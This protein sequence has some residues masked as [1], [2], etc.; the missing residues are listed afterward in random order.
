MGK[1][2][3]STVFLAVIV[4][5]NTVTVIAPT[6]AAQN[7]SVAPT[8]NRDS[9]PPPTMPEAQTKLLLSRYSVILFGSSYASLIYFDS[10]LADFMTINPEDYKSQPKAPPPCME[11]K[12]P[13]H[14][15]VYSVEPKESLL[16]GVLKDFYEYV[17]YMINHLRKYIFARAEILDMIKK[18][19]DDDKVKAVIEKS[20]TSNKRARNEDPEKSSLTN[21]VVLLA[22]YFKGF[23]ER[24]PKEDVESLKEDKTKNWGVKE[25]IEAI[26]GL[27]NQQ[28]GMKAE[29]TIY[30]NFLELEMG[31]DPNFTDRVDYKDAQA[32]KE[33]ELCIG[34]FSEQLR[35]A[36]SY[37]ENTILPQFTGAKKPE[38]LIKDIYRTI[39]RTDA[40]LK[41][42]QVEKASENNTWTINHYPR[43]FRDFEAE[44]TML[45]YNVEQMLN[46]K[47]TL[48]DYDHIFKLRDVLR[49]EHDRL[50]RMIFDF[51]EHVN[52]IPLWNGA[53][54][55]ALSLLMDT[56]FKFETW[57]RQLESVKIML[58]HIKRYS[59]A[60]QECKITDVQCINLVKTA[61]AKYN[62]DLADD[63]N[64][65]D[66]N[67]LAM[68]AFHYIVSNG[69]IT[70]PISPT[71]P[72]R[73]PHLPYYLQVLDRMGEVRKTVYK[74]MTPVPTRSQ[75]V[76]KQS[77]L[78]N[79]STITKDNWPLII[80]DT[81]GA[82]KKFLQQ[83][84]VKYP[85]NPKL[86]DYWVEVRS[87]MIEAMQ[88]WT[89][90]VDK[91]LNAMSPMRS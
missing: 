78:K 70:G 13:G 69:Q 29:L 31:E 64:Q 17:M 15:P 75:P 67:I 3:I 66:I 39:V 59:E 25:W 43:L 71:T 32:K 55:E 28:D 41:G 14:P 82:S 30:K 34:M 61:N 65:L 22:T 84:N 37:L 12:Y 38:D 68:R 48:R 47:A 72:N 35:H 51:P 24:Q 56:I 83:I 85:H 90:E 86:K 27:V 74:W 23:L 73:K 53:V 6:A 58:K 33:V 87:N 18:F 81:I 80:E 79:I 57:C 7:K 63:L 11:H 19:V 5:Y 1:I 49:G 91:V 10:L 89:N 44:F 4:F 46:L 26:Q 42:V 62:P 16:I 77:P 54:S 60:W 21:K 20:P 36:A 52:N 2:S 40:F 9:P 88:C 8:K 76:V 45:G 50:T